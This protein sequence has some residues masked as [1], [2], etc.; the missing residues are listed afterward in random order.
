[1]VATTHASAAAKAF[2]TY[3]HAPKQQAIFAAN[4]YRPV[5]K[6]VL[7]RP[8]LASWRKKY[9]TGPTFNI[10]DRLFGGWR[11]ANT[12][13]FDLSSGRMVGIERAVGGPTH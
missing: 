8:S 7:K 11:K 6:S 3:A 1:M 4:G 2:I 12:V 5:V 9:D 13:W 10:R